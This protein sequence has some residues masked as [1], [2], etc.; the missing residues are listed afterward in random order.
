MLPCFAEADVSALALPAERLLM[1]CAETPTKQVSDKH[2]ASV[3]FFILNLRFL[4]NLYVVAL[5]RE[6]SVEGKMTEIVSGVAA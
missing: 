5:G 2:N 3:V 1:S 6:D 4:L